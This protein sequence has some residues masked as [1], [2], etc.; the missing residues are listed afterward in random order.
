M[1]FD[2]LLPVKTRVGEPALILSSTV[3]MDGYPILAVITQADG[4]ERV[5]SF[6]ADGRYDGYNMCG[7]SGTHAR[8]L[9]N[10]ASGQAP[11]G[12][13]F[14]PS[15]HACAI[16][17]LGLAAA[18]FENAATVPGAPLAARYAQQARELRASIRVLQSLGAAALP[19]TPPA[20]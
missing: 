5:D 19:E 16:E 6:T 17:Q 8:D 18:Q 2:P 14:V 12:V 15:V 4:S 9:I 13:P 7:P 11:L 20:P 3:K 10:D 1:S